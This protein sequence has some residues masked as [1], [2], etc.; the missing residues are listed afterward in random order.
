MAKALVIF[1][2]GV[3]SNGEDLAALGR[4]WTPL[5]PDV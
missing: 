4:R 3:G 2:H 1:L 5:L